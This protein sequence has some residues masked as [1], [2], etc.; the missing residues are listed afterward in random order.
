MLHIRSFSAVNLQR[1]LRWHP[2]GINSWSASDWITALIGEFGEAANIVK[3]LNR[4]RDGLVGNTKSEA[5][6]RIELAEELA[7]IF[8]YLDLL[9]TSEGI[10]LEVE[11]INK[12]NKTSEKVGFAKIDNG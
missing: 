1:C 3:K 8:I 11:I 9:A 7:D 10:D 12:F 5:E 2:K 4:V 6:L